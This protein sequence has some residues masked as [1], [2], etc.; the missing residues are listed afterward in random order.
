ML[1]VGTNITVAKAGDPVILSFASCRTCRSCKTGHPAYCRDI[2]GEN[3]KSVDGIFSVGETS[4]GGSFFGQSSFSNLTIVKE[5]CVVNV[6][7]LLVRD[8]SELGL[9]APLACGFQT[10]CGTVIRLANASDED[11]ICVLGLGNV[12]LAAI[13]VEE[14]ETI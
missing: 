4:V 10:G 12:G 1:A 5:S 9:F 11:S 2:V 8:E 6:S 3:F 7:G 14:L 13:M